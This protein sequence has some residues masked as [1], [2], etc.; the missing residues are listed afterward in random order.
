MSIAVVTGVID[1]RILVNYNID[2][3]RIARVLPPPFQPKLVNG[4]AVGGI[5]LIRLKQL[6][7]RFLPAAFGF[8]SENAAHRIAVEWQQ[9]GV[10]RE[11]VYIPR[12]DTSAWLHTLLGGRAFPGT[13]HRADFTVR[14]TADRY[15]VE[16][17]ARDG[18]SRVLVD[19]VLASGLPATSVFRSVAEASSFFERGSLGYSSTLDRARF[20]GLELSAADWHVEPLAVERVESSFFDDREQF[21]EGTVR[22]DSAL[23]MQGIVHEWVAREA[24]CCGT[25][26]VCM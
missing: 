4:R 8:S 2:A 15:F 16:M 13:H 21:A 26:S 17:Q 25:S 7:P 10:T 12:R 18:G 24:L 19:A 3:D 20:E 14:E 11:G 5:C 22:F 6:R 1:R 23:L 9:D